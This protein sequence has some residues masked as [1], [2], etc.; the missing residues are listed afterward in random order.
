MARVVIEG[1]RDSAH[2]VHE[3]AAR[4]RQTVARRATRALGG[5]RARV[6]ARTMSVNSPGTS[7]ALGA[8][9]YARL[10]FDDVSEHAVRHLAQA[11]QWHRGSAYEG[12]FIAQSEPRAGACE[13]SSSRDEAR[14]ARGEGWA[15]AE[16]EFRLISNRGGG[17]RDERREGRRAVTDDDD[18]RARVYF[19]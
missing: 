10:R 9:A 6:W 5:R 13:R 17:A 15:S 3:F 12:Q 1:E 8:H 11:L 7:A 18:A 14:G 2:G 16:G 4:R 19:M